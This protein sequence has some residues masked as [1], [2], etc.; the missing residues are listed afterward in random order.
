MMPLATPSTTTRSIISRR[1]YIFTL[2]AAT[3]RIM[4]V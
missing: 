3:W 1:V 4:A 2:P